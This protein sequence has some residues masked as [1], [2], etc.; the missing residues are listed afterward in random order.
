[1]V[2]DDLGVILRREPLS[3]RLLLGHRSLLLKSNSR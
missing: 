1:M 3:Q 2:F